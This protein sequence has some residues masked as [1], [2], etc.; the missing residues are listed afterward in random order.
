MREGGEKV[1]FVD[2]ELAEVCPQGRIGAQ[3]ESELG[4]VPVLARGNPPVVE[5]RSELARQMVEE[6]V[7]QCQRGASPAHP[8][9]NP[10]GDVSCSPPAEQ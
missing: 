5:C 2:M 9:T 1:Q 10:G 6:G 4:D 7:E 8:V 3:C